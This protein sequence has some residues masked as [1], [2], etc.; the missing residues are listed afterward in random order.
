MQNKLRIL[1]ADDEAI[2]R[3]GLKSMLQ[4]MG[5]EALLAANGREALDIARTANPDLAILDIRMPLTDGLEAAKVIAR[6]HPM[7][8]LLLT[9]Y[10]EQ[11][12]IRK[13]AEL[14]IQSYL[15]KPVDERDLSAAIQIAIA[16]FADAQAAQ[17]KIVELEETIET[18]KLVE[19]AKGLLIKSGLTE[20]AAYLTIQ[21]RARDERTSMRRVAEDILKK[22]GSA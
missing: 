16:R 10:S 11:D 1:V 6:K 17:E 7:P 12:L 22:M 4:A 3:L 21:R 13:A 8:V 18:R 2:I 14:P 19:K 15:I 5:H 9:A 20:E